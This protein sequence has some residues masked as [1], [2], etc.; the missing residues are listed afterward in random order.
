MK[1]ENYWEA[2]FDF[3]GRLWVDTKN[4]YGD[5]EKFGFSVHI[6]RRKFIDIFIETT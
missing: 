2:S 3:R 4:L 1:T 5:F 6:G